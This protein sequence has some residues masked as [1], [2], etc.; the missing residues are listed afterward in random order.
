MQIRCSKKGCKKH[1]KCSK[2]EPKWEPK[3]RKSLSKR[4]SENLCEK[5]TACPDPPGGS[6]GRAGAPILSSRLRLRLAFVFA[7]SLAVFHCLTTTFF[8]PTVAICHPASS[9]QTSFDVLWRLFNVFWSPLIVRLRHVRHPNVCKHT[10]RSIAK[11]TDA[12]H[13]L[14]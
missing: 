8:V 7:S 14:G 13:S 3:S 1:E 10:D 6:A 9:R 4:R 5:R 12:T 2:M 11:A